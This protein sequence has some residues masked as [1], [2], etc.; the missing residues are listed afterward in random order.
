MAAKTKNKPT[1]SI[2]IP[3]LNEAR[4][5]NSLIEHLH[6]LHSNGICE[7][8]VVDGSPEQN[9]VRAIKYNDIIAISAPKGRGRQMNA[10]AAIARGDTLI[11]LHADTQLPHNA[12]NS[13]DQFL[14]ENKFV[15]G[16]FDLGIKSHKLSLKIIAFGANFR[17]HFTHIPYGDQAIF[18][19]RDYFNK[20][21]GYKDIPVMEDIELMHRIKRLGGKIR[22]LSD[23]VVTS[24]RRW[25]KEGVVY[26]TLRNWALSLLFFLDIPSQ[27]LE[28]FFKQGKDAYNR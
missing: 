4:T 21:G 17:T 27:K 25:E 6:T 13:I 18:I 5:I 24:P 9:T 16:A 14:E 28:K 3:V 7:I 23:R 19:R 20:I 10:G 11:F 15:G 22:I 12:L 8:I 2:I 1:F 26:C